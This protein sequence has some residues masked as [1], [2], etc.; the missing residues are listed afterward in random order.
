[1]TVQ[2]IRERRAALLKEARDLHEA[3]EA[4]GRE[5]SAAEQERWASLFEQA[6]SLGRALKRGERLADVEAATRETNVEPATFAMQ[7]QLGHETPEREVWRDSSG[8]EV[9]VFGPGER[10]AKRSNPSCL[11]NVIRQR[12]LNPTSIAEARA[13]IAGV[14]PAG[15]YGVG[16]ELS[17]EFVDLVRNRAVCV[18]AGARTVEMTA[19]EMTI[20]RAISDIAPEFIGEM[21][22]VPSSEP[23][24]GAATLKARLLAVRVPVSGTWW[25]DCPNASAI[26]SDMIAGAMATKLDHAILEGSGVGAEPR[27]ILN[28]DGIQTVTSVGVPTDYA[29]LAAGVAAIW[30]ANGEPTALIYS[31]RTAGQLDVLQDG[32]TNPLVPPPSVANLRQFRTNGISNTLGAG[33][34]SWACIGDFSNVL[35]GVRLP[36]QVV[37][38]PAADGAT[39]SYHVVAVMRVDSVCTRP[40]HMCACTG[41]TTA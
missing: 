33:A 17:T 8:K 38:V 29:E 21:G 41:I 18:A 2:E 20:L 15:G 11:G 28:T 37:V 22:T 7:Q 24:F 5:F 9:R 25:Q 34:E 1:M 27:G 39:Y 3:A 14:D 26:V 4:E 32:D 40:A 35:V 16:V 23:S 31:A 12:M 30:G 13:L 36:L 10:L 19:G 6:D